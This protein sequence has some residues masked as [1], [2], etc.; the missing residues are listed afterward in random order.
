MAFDTLRSR[1]PSTGFGASAAV[2][3]TLLALLV[4][5]PTPR[6]G[7]PTVPDSLRFTL[8]VPDTVRTG[9]PVRITLH[10]TNVTTHPV[11]A[12]FMGRDI[13]FDI[14]VAGKDDRVVWRRLAH[15]VV[16]GILQVKVLAPQER[17]EFSD[18]W[19]QTDEQGERVAPGGYTVW[20]ELPSDE[21]EPRRT[22][23]S[24]LRITP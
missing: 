4:T 15:A 3:A 19:R 17:L 14:V 12:H 21:R 9:Q 6:R 24:T 7:P 10:L 5:A 8:V 1:A 11:E 13:A 20:G 18:V 2:L 22:D 16:P 23:K